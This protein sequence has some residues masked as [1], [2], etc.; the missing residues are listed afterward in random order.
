LVS[1]K[2]YKKRKNN[3]EKSMTGIIP[4]YVP[5]RIRLKAL[6]YQKSLGTL[7]NS[8]TEGKGTPAAYVGK[9]MVADYLGIHCVSRS[10]HE[11][12]VYYGDRINVKSV[13]CSSQPFGFYD[14]SITF[15]V[16]DFQNIDGFIFTR[17]SYNYR[18]VW[19]CG[20][21]SKKDH[22]EKSRKMRTGE[23]DLNNGYKCSKGCY[24]IQIKDLVPLSQYMREKAC[25]IE[26]VLK[27]FEE[28]P[29]PKGIKR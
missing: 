1:S 7:K 12:F 18:R 3:R 9:M 16:D 20:Y 15:D 25:S 13:R 29:L 6:E 23:V 14:V 11:N 27:K 17:V 10:Y 19:I 2:R 8:I 28:A 21:Q 22:K 4:L 26:G 24:K 5:D